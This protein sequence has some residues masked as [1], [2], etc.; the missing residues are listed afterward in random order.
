MRALRARARQPAASADAPTPG[1]QS[2]PRN[3]KR[4]QTFPR[5]SKLF[6]SF[7]QGFPNFFLG[8]FEGN[9]WLV[10]ERTR[11]RFFFPCRPDAGALP[12]GRPDPFAVR[13]L[14]ELPAHHG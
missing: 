8:G 7:F 14:A 9:Q 6:P 10:S 12:P 11:I 5:I 4:F 1:A 2:F 13:R 3:S